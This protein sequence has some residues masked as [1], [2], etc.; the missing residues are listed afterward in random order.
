MTT[1]LTGAVRHEVARATQNDREGRISADD[2]RKIRTTGLDAVRDSQRPNQT[3][4]ATTRVISGAMAQQPMSD[5]TR[6][7]LGRFAKLG[8]AEVA[9]PGAVGPAVP[10][11]LA[12]RVRQALEN[13]L[14]VAGGTIGATTVLAGQTYVDLAIAHPLGK[15]SA[16]VQLAEDAAGKPIVGTASILSAPV[17]APA[18][19]PASPFVYSE[20]A[21][22]KT[23]LAEITRHTQ[24]L[25]LHEGPVAHLEVWLRTGALTPSKLERIDDPE[26]SPVGLEPGQAQFAARRVWGDIAVFYTVDKSTGAAST[27]D[28]N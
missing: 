17:L 13:S 11:P 20:A 14:G 7:Y 5:A 21:A 27:N 26:E 15:V 4:A 6:A 22:R 2:A 19:P 28:F 10:S 8:A 16:R 23:A 25:A 18:A 1:T 3:L 9:G 12:D 24:A